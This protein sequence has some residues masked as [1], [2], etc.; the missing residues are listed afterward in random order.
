MRNGFEQFTE[1]VSRCSEQIGIFR[2][3]YNRT[4]SLAVWQPEKDLPRQTSAAEVK[5][6]TAKFECANV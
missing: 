4:Y 3:A 2:G 1:N 5:N 6:S